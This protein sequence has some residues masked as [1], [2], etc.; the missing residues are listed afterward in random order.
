MEKTKNRKHSDEFKQEAV[1]MALESGKPKSTVA[2]ELDI[3]TDLLYDWIKKYDQATSRGLTVTELK[4]E[5]EELRQL[6][7][8]VKNLQQE[9]AILKKAAAYFAR[10]QL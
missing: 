2:R 3:S 7:A 1:R 5:Q 10:D 6:K 9:N 8:Q 4:A